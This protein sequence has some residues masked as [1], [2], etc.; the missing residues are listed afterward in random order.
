VIAAT[1]R[2]ELIDPA[3]I[4]PGRLD[5]LLYVSLPTP[6]DRVSILMALAVKVNLAQDVDL[7][8]LARS[9]RADGFSGADC[10]ALLREAGLAVLKESMADASTKL[11]I[12]RRHFDYAFDHVLPS[13]SVRDQQRYD[14]MRDRMARVRTRVG[15]VN[16]EALV[17]DVGDP[18]MKDKS[19]EVASAAA[20]PLVGPRL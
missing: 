11:E 17:V 2:P 19:T 16:D 6:S 10:A 13:V 8:A 15:G 18:V 9:H 5:K 14:K 3:M 20:A 4:R 7:D 1:N 12:T